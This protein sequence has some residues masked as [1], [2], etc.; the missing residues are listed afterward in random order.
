M[1][2]L[3]ELA[4]KRNF[5]EVETSIADYILQNPE[6][7]CTLGIAELARRTYSSNAAIIR[8]CRKLGISGY[9]EFRIAFA[10]DLEKERR[11]KVDVDVNYPFAGPES[12]ASIMRSVAN[13]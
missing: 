10:A 5:S 1:S 7:V 11:E 12:A 4:E 2:I 8:M 6:E 9:K 13:T 3:G